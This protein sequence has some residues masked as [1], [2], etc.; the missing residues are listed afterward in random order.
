[1]KKNGF[2]L[3]ELLVVISIIAMLSSIMLAGL[4]NARM[5]A[6][7]TRRIQD[8]KQIQNAL[9]MYRND[10]GKY[11]AMCGN[12]GWCRSYQL[13]T[14][15]TTWITLQNALSKYISKLPVDPINKLIMPFGAGGYSYMYR[16]GVGSCASG[17]CYDL[18]G[19]LEDVNSPY[20]CGVKKYIDF[21]QGGKIWCPSSPSDYTQIYSPQ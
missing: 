3:I 16:S 10:N 18:V 4:N 21:F 9:E 13:T 15:P 17:D 7:D 8:L 20:R 12:D 1:M 5:K 2:T 19:R 11:P 6:R 14:A